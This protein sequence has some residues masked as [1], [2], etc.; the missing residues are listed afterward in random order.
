VLDVTLFDDSHDIRYVTIDV[1]GS[2]PAPT[3][4]PTRRPAPTATPEPGPAPTPIPSTGDITDSSRPR[5]STLEGTWAAAVNLSLSGAA[6]TPQIVAAPDGR[7]W[8]FWWDE[9]NGL[10]ATSYDPAEASSDEPW[11]PPVV[12]PII[13]TKLVGEGRNAEWVSHSVGEMPSIV[14]AGRYAHAFWLG[15]PD[16]D[17]GL[18]PLMHSRLSLGA[19][20]ARSTA[21]AWSGGQALAETALVWRLTRAPDG[22]LHLAYV[23]PVH[24]AVYPAGVYHR[25]SLDN[26]AS[27]GPATVLYG[28]IYYRR[29]AAEEA[30]L[31]LAA[32]GEGRVFVTWDD[33]RLE[34]SFMAVSTD[35]GASWAQSVGVPGHALQ[36]PATDSGGSPPRTDDGVRRARVVP[37]ANDVLLL[38]EEKAAVSGCALYQQRLVTATATVTAT[39]GAGQRVLDDLNTCPAAPLFLQTPQSDPLMLGGGG[40]EALTLVAWR[41]ATGITSTLQPTTTIAASTALTAT[42]LGTIAPGWSE[43]KSLS[44]SFQHPE[45]DR[46]VYLSQLRATLASGKLAVVGLDQHGDVWYLESTVDTWEWA[47]APPPAWAGPVNI[48]QSAGRPGGPTMA[49]DLEGR[50]HAVWS[51]ATGDDAPGAA[52]YYA[53]LEAPGAAAAVQPVSGGAAGLSA[54][55][56]RPAQVL[57]SPEGRAEQAALA[58]YEDRLYAVWIGGQGDRIYASQAYGR[59]AYAPGGWSQAEEVPMGGVTASSPRLLVDAFGLRH[60]VYAAP[61][62]EGRG[63]Y[64]TSADVGSSGLPG[65]AVRSWTLPQV[66]FDAEAAGWAMVDH[67]TLA[68]DPGG[69]LHVA[70]VRGSSAGPF[71]PQG[72]YYARSTDGGETW[73][74]AR[75]MAEGAYVWPQVAA[76]LIGQVHLLWNQ[77][78]SGAAWTHR[79]S[80]DYGE[81]WSFEQQVRG[82]RD[83]PGPV[84]LAAD[85][86]GGLYLV[87]LGQDDFDEPA[88]VYSVWLLEEERWEEQ[89]PFRVGPVQGVLPG[90]ALTLLGADGRIDALFRA[91][92]PGE[93]GTR[94]DVLHAQRTVPPVAE[95]P[96]PL[97]TPVPTLTPLPSPTPPP[98]PTPRPQVEVLPPGAAPPTVGLGPVT[99]PVIAVA[100]LALA[101]LIIVG[102]LVASRRDRGR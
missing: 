92:V 73:S 101:L 14:G 33:P 26:G 56:S 32:D 74:E 9:F 5:S 31:A 29:L 47:F 60:L 40:G 2:C 62:N 30:H 17:T 80:A 19:P 78:G 3:L 55:W 86:L 52:L 75:Q 39:W 45:F 15:Q 58:T 97:Y 93:E 100:G 51:E 11:S 102:V 6:S 25:R 99:L 96:E 71:A 7:L 81:T 54:R 27:W 18:N 23:R 42:Q 16:E 77:A 4:R 10:I 41:G 85:G 68:M 12:V 79:W 59:D 95:A 34:K 53:R 64:Y 57:Q 89:A 22:T 63:I 61:L 37:T 35:G 94:R 70:W 46:Q 20:P 66:V 72:I 13:V 65:L 38:W 49:A 1:N 50:V 67:P 83:V 82:F 8:A 90:V 84:G 98:T 91:Q 28:D 88:L 76:P 48:S 44:F 87:G 21:R 43:P 24:S 36:A 69:T